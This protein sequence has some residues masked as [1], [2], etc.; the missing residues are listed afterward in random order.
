MY[1]GVFTAVILLVARLGGW[2][3]LTGAIA[4]VDA[5][6]GTDHLS[7]TTIGFPKVSSWVIASL[8][9]ACTA[10]AGIQPVLASK[11]VPTARKACIYTALVTAPFGLMTALIGIV[12]KVMSTFRAMW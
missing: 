6:E 4:Q 1:I 8:L 5:Q 9:G 10:Q 12:G 3:Q 7:M 11:D 2:D